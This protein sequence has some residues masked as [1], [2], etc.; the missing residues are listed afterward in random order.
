MASRS[1]PSAVAATERFRPPMLLASS[2]ST[3][4]IVPAASTV[5]VTAP[6]GLTARLTSPTLRVARPV[7]S[8][9]PSSRTVA[10]IVDTSAGVIESSVRLAGCADL[11]LA[12]AS[13]RS[14]SRRWRSNSSADG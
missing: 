12:S 10:A 11:A 7:E 1:D 9:V 4:T 8:A 3:G 5:P 14:A 6:E 2:E 13:M